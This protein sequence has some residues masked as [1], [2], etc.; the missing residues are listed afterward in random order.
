MNWPLFHS[1][2]L[3]HGSFIIAWPVLTIL[4]FIVIKTIPIARDRWNRNKT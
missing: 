2:G 4:S 3:V 1:W